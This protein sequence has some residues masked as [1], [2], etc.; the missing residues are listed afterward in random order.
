MP[1]RLGISIVFQSGF[2][3]DVTQVPSVGSNRAQKGGHTMLGQ[4]VRAI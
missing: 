1:M 2:I 4:S 3:R